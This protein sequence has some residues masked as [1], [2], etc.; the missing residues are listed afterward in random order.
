MAN[1]TQGI[2]KSN[3]EE[4]AHNKKT[5]AEDKSADRATAASERDTV[6]QSRHVDRS[7]RGAGSGENAVRVRQHKLP[8]RKAV[9]P[10]VDITEYPEGDPDKGRIDYEAQAEGFVAEV[11]PMRDRRAYL[12]EQAQRNQDA[13]D[14]LNAIQV[15]QN[16]NLQFAQSQLQ[17]PDVMRENSMVTAVAALK[18]HNTMQTPDYIEKAKQLRE[19]RYQEQRLMIPHV[20]PVLTPE[21]QAEKHAAK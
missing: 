1:E 11:I 17:D 2:R 6:P 19:E 4:D 10:P 20:G 7:P 15:E 21:E 13:N 5:A 8:P 12:L 9:P 18:E 16:R 14:E 3:A